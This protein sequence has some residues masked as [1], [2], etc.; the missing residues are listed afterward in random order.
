MK[1]YVLLHV[2]ISLIEILKYPYM[3]LSDQTSLGDQFLLLS[4]GYSGVDRGGA[5]ART[6]PPQLHKFSP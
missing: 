3:M 1:M 2:A 6:L 4:N 5:Q